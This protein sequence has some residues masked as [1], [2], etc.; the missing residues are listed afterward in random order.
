MICDLLVRLPFPLINLD[1]SDGLDNPGSDLDGIAGYHSDILGGAVTLCCKNRSSIVAVHGLGAHPVHT[2]CD[3]SSSAR[4]RSASKTSSEY[5]QA[6]LDG[7]V[8]SVDTCN[9]GH[10]HLLRDLLRP[11]F[12]DARILSFAHN[13]DWFVNAPVATAQEIGYKLL[14]QLAEARKHNLRIPI[15]FVC[16]SFGGIIVKKVSKLHSD[17]VS[18]HDRSQKALCRPGVVS[19]EILSNTRGIIFLGTPH[20]GSPAS[21][22]G[23]I[24]ATMTAVLGSNNTLL[25]SL[26][27]HHNEL[28]DLEELF[29]D[30]MKDEEQR[31]EKTQIFSFYETMQT[32]LWWLPIGLVVTRDSARTCG[33]KPIPINTHHSGLNKPQDELSREL[34]RVIEGLKENAKPTPSA[35][36]QYVMDKLTSVKG[37]VFDPYDE[38]YKGECLDGTRVDLLRQIDQWADDPEGK[39]IFWLQGMAGTGK[40]TISRTV[41][42]KFDDGDRLGASFFFK[43]GEGDRDRA[44]RFFPTLVRQLVLQI[45][46]LSYPVAEAIKA[47]PDISSKMPEVIRP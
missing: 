18:A 41:A 35:N 1:T 31:Q 37:A 24:L 11:K 4:K 15:I 22:A 29:A 21:I 7:P 43:R 38:D 3:T 8:N 17:V 30:R 13:S 47:N 36:Q 39:S 14:D 32:T 10:F 5:T 23:A 9:K 40:S 6:A 27:D 33:A 20:Q 26:R 34:I 44:S 2:W 12:P 25:L 46:A 45:P 19:E 16:H 28:S 42:R